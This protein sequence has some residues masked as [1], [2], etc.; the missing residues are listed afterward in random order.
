MD[1]LSYHFWISFGPLAL[2]TSYFVIAL[3]IFPFYY[4]KLKKLPDLIENR[5]HSRILNKWIRYWWMWVIS[6][7]FKILLRSGLTPNQISVLGTLLAALSTLAFAFSD[8]WIGISS[9]GIGG[10]LMVLGGSMDF[11]DG[12]VA[13]QTGQESESGAF[14]DSCLDRIAESLVLTGLAWY[15]R[16][17]WALWLVMAAFTGSMMTSYSKCRGDKM[18]IEYSGGIM[19]RPERVVYLGVG[20]IFTPEIGMLVYKFFPDYFVS[21]KAATDFVYTIPLLFVA[22]LS[23]YT[24][25]DRIKNIMCLLD[26]RSAAK[27]QAAG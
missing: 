21:L 16:D 20:G 3:L 24:T 2:F 5:H 22:I 26:K 13:R 14:F 19:Q 25:Y 11:M 8:A 27:K 23:N 17:S 7:L 1:F 4:P 6:P 9:F 12:W 10:W 18:G 15:F